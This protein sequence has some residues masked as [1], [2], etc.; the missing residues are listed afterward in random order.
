MDGTSSSL[1]DI[2]SE[3]IIQILHHC[4]YPSIL[5]FAATCKVYYELVAQSTS[6]QLHIELEVNGLELLKGSFKR[7]ADYLVILKELRRFRD[8]WL[9]LDFVDPV[10]RSAGNSEMLLWELREGFYIRA[11]SRSAL[12]LFSDT[13]QF[14]PLDTELPDP[15][16]LSF[17]FTFNEFTADPAQELLAILS[18]GPQRDVHVLL[19]SSA[20]GLAH[21]LARHSRLS[22]EFDFDPPHYWPGFSIEIM[23]DIVV[24]KVSLPHAYVY[25]LLV[26][27]WKYGILLHRIGSRDGICDYTFLD[28]KHLVVFSGSQSTP[29]HLD[30]LSLLIYTLS[31]DTST[32]PPLLSTDQIRLSD[33]LISQPTLLLEFPQ[34]KKSSGLSEMGFFL[35]SQPAPG[36]AMHIGSATFACSHAMT[37]SMTFSPDEDAENWGYHPYYRVFIDGKFLH[38]QIRNNLGDMTRILPW[39]AYGERATRWF[40]APEE[41]GHWI[42]WMSGSRFITSLPQHPNYCIFDFS[43]PIVHR[44]RDRF[45]ELNPATHDHTDDFFTDDASFKDL[46]LLGNDIHHFSVDP[47]AGHKFFAFTVD[48]DKPSIIGTD[49]LDF[50]EPIISRLPYRV[51]FRTDAKGN[52]GGWQ[53]NG[54]C[55]VGI[56]SRGDSENLTIYRVRREE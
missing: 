26:W 44:F 29:S 25:E 36:R 30:T 14:T 56:S 39:S 24:A 6:L 40:V 45:T 27:N 31:D 17:D 8:A 50:E 21:P 5:S 35:R 52:H 34:F 33:V 10:E 16:P 51:A 49:Y 43:P 41:P 22:A 20:T 48:E 13:I 32:R 4:E 18:R 11:F 54:D 42:C 9:D 38:D 12:G 53:I 23:Q 1:C 46:T 47:P 55:V 19:C 15:P 28:R 7:D 3:L 37:L 2:S